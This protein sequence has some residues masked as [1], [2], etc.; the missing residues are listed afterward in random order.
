MECL[1][2]YVL[3]REREREF[4]KS[5]YS[6]FKLLKI[7]NKSYHTDICLLGSIIKATINKQNFNLT[8]KLQQKEK[9]KKNFSLNTIKQQ[10]LH[11]ENVHV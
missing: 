4:I 10:K 2:D 3:E 9:K 6:C 1:F 7:K 11:E 8:S 5:D